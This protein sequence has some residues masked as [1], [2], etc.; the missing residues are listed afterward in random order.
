MDNRERF[1]GLEEALRMAF[2]A[3]RAS[4]WTTLP[5]IVVAFD[6]E[7]VTAKVQPALQGVIQAS[8]GTAS[9]VNLPLLIHCPVVFQRGGGVSL[10]F[11][12]KPGDECVLHFSARCIDGWWQAGGIQLPM[13]PRLHDLSDA[14]CVVGPQ[15]QVKKISGISTTAAQLRT[16]DG[17]AF[18]ELDA[19]TGQIKILTP[20]NAVIDATGSVIANTPGMLVSGNVSVGGGWTGSISSPTGLTVTFMNGIAI[21]GE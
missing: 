19:S 15:S 21:S 8:D 17:S 5:G 10:T 6:P 7:E 2:R 14:F 18:V 1:A 4:I 20:T 13:E 12:I 3:E 16:D 9:A 11:P